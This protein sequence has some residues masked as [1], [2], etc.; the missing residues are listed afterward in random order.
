MASS[1]TAV[2]ALSTFSYL[3]GQRTVHDELRKMPG[4]VVDRALQGFPDAH[5]IREAT[6]VQVANQLPDLTMAGMNV[7]NH[8]DSGPGR[9]TYGL[10]VYSRLAG[11][12]TVIA[13]KQTEGQD[14]ELV[15]IKNKRKKGKLLPSEGYGKW[16]PL[17]NTPSHFAD[18]PGGGVDAAEEA[19]LKKVSGAQAYAEAEKKFEFKAR[20]YGP[21]DGSFAENACRELEEELGVTL[22]PTDLEFIDGRMQYSPAY[23]L[24]THVETFLAILPHDTCFKLDPEEV[25]SLHLIHPA[26]IM[27]QSDGS[28]KVVGFGEVI[29]APYME[30][31]QIA[32][33]RHAENQLAQDSHGLILNMSQLKQYATQLGFPDAPFIACGPESQG[34]AAAKK[35]LCAE[36]TMRLQSL[37]KRQDSLVFGSPA[38][39][40]QDPVQ[41]LSGN[42][43]GFPPERE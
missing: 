30:K 29:P 13:L 25:E 12:A 33:L 34:S 11:G 40:P 3:Y 32:L 39:S 36:V 10:Q 7:T 6:I 15:L 16:A 24:Q 17:Q 22:K 21:F 9:K 42:L 14:V 41:S 20:A 26:Q 28:A 27:L 31:I 8:L 35:V 1:I 43:T 38:A 18:L 37:I 5:K 23:G 19:I 2:L 4:K